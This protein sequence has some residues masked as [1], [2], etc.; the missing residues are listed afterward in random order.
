MK[1]RTM[2]PRVTRS[3]DLGSNT[4]KLRLEQL[5]TRIVLDS[6]VVFNEVFYHPADG[7][8]T[9]E[10]IEVYN[11][12]SVNVD[13]SGWKLTGGVEFEFP[14]GTIVEAD[15]YLTI[16]A[17]PLLLAGSLGPFSGSLANNGE[18]LQL[19]NNSSRIMDV[20]DYN[21]SGDWPV[22]ADGSGASLAKI[23]KLTSSSEPSNWAASLAVGGTPGAMNFTTVFSNQGEVLLDDNFE[24]ANPSATL[25]TGLPGDTGFWA[26]PWSARAINDGAGIWKID[27]GGLGGTP[28]N[29]VTYVR[30]D[31]GR[32]TE[33]ASR[34]FSSDIL[35]TTP[36]YFSFRFKHDAAVGND[37]IDNTFATTWHIGP[38]GRLRVGFEGGTLFIESEKTGSPDIHRTYSS[39]QIADGSTNDIVIKLEQDAGGGGSFPGTAELI[40]VY[41]NPGATEPAT[42]D[43]IQN[44]GASIAFFSGQEFMGVDLESNYAN[45]QA[46][47]ID[48]LRIGTTYAQV[49]PINPIA[50]VIGTEPFDAYAP[51]ATLNGQE[52]GGGDPTWIARNVF[53]GQGVWTTESPGL[54]GTNLGVEYVRAASSR[55]PETASRNISSTTPSTT[56]HYFGFLF[57]HDAAQGVDTS[58]NI[59]ETSWAFDNDRGVRVG[60][61]GTNVFIE[62]FGG[63]STHRTIDTHSLIQENTTHQI[64]IKVEQDAGGMGS[65]PGTAELISVF[66]D[67]GIYRACLC[68]FFTE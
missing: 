44:D 32:V 63:V 68:Q 35:S 6:T 36:H 25:N 65:F 38:T 58:N 59:F 30:A 19:V 51:G 61:E 53:D 10:W 40:S 3:Q 66:V 22:A 13:I 55:N 31:S 39:I 12:Q 47:T 62:T 60:V 42:P 56:T 16:A 48:N 43:F 45:G 54:G 18:E 29:S 5:E 52:G 17:D 2:I 15:S 64:V 34:G 49:A 46:A 50:A 57:E 4:R 27:A 37:A 33:I 14:E 67:P 11:Q 8:S 28:G 20:V 1:R 23:D 21:D 41:V 9:P 7:D 26:G 24:S